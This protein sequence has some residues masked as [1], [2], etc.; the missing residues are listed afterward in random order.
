MSDDASVHSSTDS[1]HSPVFDIPEFPSLRRVKPLPKRRRTSDRASD[2]HAPSVAIAPSTRSV[3][4]V[5]NGNLSL[6]VA[7]EDLAKALSTT[8]A[9]QSYYM[10]IFNGVLAGAGQHDDIGLSH[11]RPSIHESLAFGY[12]DVGCAGDEA[13]Q[14]DG[15][16]TDHLQQ[17]GNTKKRKVPVNASSRIGDANSVNSGEEDVSHG[18]VAIGR[19]DDTE[20]V[21]AEDMSPLPPPPPPLPSHVAGTAMNRNRLSAAANAALKHKDL[22]R[23]RK[24]QLVSLL[25]TLA[26]GDT[27]ALDMALCTSYSLAKLVENGQ[28]QGANN[29]PTIRLSRRH[30]RRRTRLALMAF[31]KGHIDSSLNVSSAHTP[32]RT[33]PSDRSDGTGEF[34]CDFT[35]ECT[36]PSELNSIPYFLFPKDAHHSGAFN[37]FS[38]LVI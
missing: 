29:D 8:M 18:F 14:G 36:S 30:A 16:L 26:Q 34:S 21:T 32:S 22:L 1:A 7:T 9:L 20:A 37:F 23:C 17:P 3:S 28:G 4:A 19:R 24:R 12:S 2:D 5:D 15:D 11:V 27:L 6:D 13:D 33:E 35:Y 38:S 31:T 10:P 25:G